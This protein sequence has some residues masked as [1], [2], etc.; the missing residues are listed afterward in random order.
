LLSFEKIELL[1]FG[2]FNRL[3]ERTNGD[4]KMKLRRF[5]VSVVCFLMFGMAINPANASEYNDNWPI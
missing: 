3:H 1:R 4:G 5:F 2:M